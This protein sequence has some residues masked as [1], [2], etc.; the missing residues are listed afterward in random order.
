[1]PTIS[2]FYPTSF[3]SH[4]D[5]KGKSRAL[6][7]ASVGSELVG[8]DQQRK[9]VIAFSGVRKRLICNK[10]NF[11]TISGFLGPD[12]DSWIGKTIELYPDRTFFQGKQVPC[13]RVREPRN[14]G[15]LQTHSEPPKPLVPPASVS[16]P[17]IDFGDVP[18]AAGLGPDIDDAIPF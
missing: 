9:C 7:I 4:D 8:Q 10:T 3:I 14:G 1:M 6:T 13:L 15:G 18:P 11:S 2:D 17:P 5:L 12:S 16:Q